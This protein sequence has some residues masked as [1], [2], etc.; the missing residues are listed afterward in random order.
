MSAAATDIGYFQDG[1]HERQRR[2]VLD[3]FALACEPLRH[4]GDYDFGRT[5]LAA[6][7]RDAGLALSTKSDAWHT[8]PADAIFLHRKLG[9]LYL[10]AARVKARVNLHALAERFAVAHPGSPASPGRSR[11][12]SLDR[13]AF[14]P[15]RP[16]GEMSG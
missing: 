8:P 9:G 7:L 12:R 16:V 13:P 2:A 6:R 11:A 3:I 5:D 14:H 15:S 10:L 1:I 4:A